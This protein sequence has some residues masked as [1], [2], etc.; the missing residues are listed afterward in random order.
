MT[1]DEDEVDEIDV[2]DKC[3]DDGNPLFMCDKDPRNGK[4]CESCFVKLGC[5][6]THGED[7]E[8]VVWE[9]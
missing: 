6:Q 1:Y 8:T 3:G 2:C 4:Y 5:R 9:S 7:C